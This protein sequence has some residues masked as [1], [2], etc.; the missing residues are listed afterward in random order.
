MIHHFVCNYRIPGICGTVD[1]FACP[2][3]F[4]C[5]SPNPL[6]SWHYC[7]LRSS[8]QSIL[9]EINPEYS[10]EGLTLKLK[11]QCLGHLMR[12]ANSLEKTLILGKMEGS[13]RRGWQRMSWLDSITD[14]TDMN[15]NK[16]QG[17]KEPGVLQFTGLQDIRYDLATKQQIK[18]EWGQKSGALTQQNWCTS[19]TRTEDASSFRVH[20]GKATWGN[21]K[22][23][24]VLQGRRRGCTSNHTS[25]LISAFELQNRE[26][27]KCLLCKP[28]L[29]AILSWQP[30]LTKTHAVIHTRCSF[31]SYQES[32]HFS[33]AKRIAFKFLELGHFYVFLKDF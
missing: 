20:R 29:D 21:S 6:P 28:P 31:F 2:C 26:K 33:K 10:L 12:R 19:G 11:L 22:E 32:V 13:W 7:S 4:I 3:K 15:L 17:Q 9:R 1:S 5:G 16:L 27:S 30:G 24:E 25:T 18:V 8:N 23:A 14:S